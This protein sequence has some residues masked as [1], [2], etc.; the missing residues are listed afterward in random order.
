MSNA[1]SSSSGSRG[2]WGR[3]Q[4]RSR[5]L[6]R[7]FESKS[8]RRPGERCSIARLSVLEYDAS[9]EAIA[10]LERAAQSAARDVMVHQM[11]LNVYDARSMK[12]GTILLGIGALLLLVL[13]VAPIVWR[14]TRVVEPPIQ[15][16]PSR[17]R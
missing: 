2:K 11:A 9:R 16:I 10:T 4:R 5:R 13:L 14:A 12:R 17:T 7:A 1:R 15:S 3:E 6:A 8:S